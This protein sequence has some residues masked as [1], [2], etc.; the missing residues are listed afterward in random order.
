MTL[1]VHRLVGCLRRSLSA[2]H[3]SSAN[4]A[5]HFWRFSR[6]T[7]T[8]D[9]KMLPSHSSW[10]VTKNAWLAFIA[11]SPRELPSSFLNQSIEPSSSPKL[12]VSPGSSVSRVCEWG[13]LYKRRLSWQVHW[14]PMSHCL[15]HSPCQICQ[16]IFLQVPYSRTW[17]RCQ[18]A[19]F[20]RASGDHLC[21]FCWLAHS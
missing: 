7:S 13:R 15:D 20:Q 9:S 19:I 5:S 4:Q 16:S 14:P 12:F 17:A 8:L 11:F 6:V 10:L 18:G 21:A 1:R 2:T 3:A